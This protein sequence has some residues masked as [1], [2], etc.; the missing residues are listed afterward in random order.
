MLLKTGMKIQ[1]AETNLPYLEC[2][3]RQNVSR[4]Y[5]NVIMSFIF[6]YIVNTLYDY[7]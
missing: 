2:K 5:D 4:L 3:N 6:V 7:I 1:L